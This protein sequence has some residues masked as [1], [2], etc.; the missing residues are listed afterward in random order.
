MTELCGERW[1]ETGSPFLNASD[2]TTQA[3]EA[4]SDLSCEFCGSI[5][6]ERDEL[7]KCERQI[8]SLRL[9]VLRLK[10]VIGLIQ[11]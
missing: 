7:I 10:S 4:V 1:L 3:D 9:E 2:N 8:N 6:N 11:S 5:C